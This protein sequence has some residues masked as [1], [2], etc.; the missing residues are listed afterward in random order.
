MISMKIV[1]CQTG[2]PFPTRN[3]FGMRDVD[4][5]VGY[6]QITV[7]IDTETG[8]DPSDPLTCMLTMA[9]DTT[10]GPQG[11]SLLSK[12]YFFEA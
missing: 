2:G 11:Q 4:G 1:A 8:L 5:V 6:I 10:M 9:V 3:E 12:S 7:A